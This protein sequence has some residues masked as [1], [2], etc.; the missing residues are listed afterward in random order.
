MLTAPFPQAP[1]HQRQPLPLAG[2]PCPLNCF[3]DDTNTPWEV[4]A[5]PEPPES[6]DPDQTQVLPWP[7]G[8]TFV[9][10]KGIGG[11]AQGGGADAAAETL[12][13]EEVA[14]RAQPLHDIHA[15]LAE[16]TG[17]AATHVQGKRLPY[18]LLAGTRHRKRRAAC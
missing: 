11:Q 9:N 8:V 4:L 3:P 13:V 6:R 15:L 12:P 7:L 2:D 18:G 16:V 10:I 5:V 1:A 17:V 14:L